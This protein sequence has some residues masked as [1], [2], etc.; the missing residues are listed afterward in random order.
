MKTG[1]QGFETKEIQYFVCLSVIYLQNKT[2]LSGQYHLAKGCI[3]Q[4]IAQKEVS[5]SVYYTENIDFFLFSS[6][7]I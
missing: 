3:N 5:Y 1:Y 6:S 4:N 7:C 2:L